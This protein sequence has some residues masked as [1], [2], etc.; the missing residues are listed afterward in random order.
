MKR[1]VLPTPR[2]NRTFGMQIQILDAVTQKLEVY[3]TTPS[4]ITKLMRAWRAVDTGTPTPIYNCLFVFLLPP[5]PV[6]DKKEDRSGHLKINLS[7][8]INDEY[9]FYYFKLN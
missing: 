9:N 1:R 4:E 2:V 5:W 8:V 3:P 7:K 6:T